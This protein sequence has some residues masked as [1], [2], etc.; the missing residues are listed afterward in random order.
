MTTTTMM[1]SI[2]QTRKHSFG[3]ISDSTRF[4]ILSHSIHSITIKK[5]HEYYMNR[6]STKEWTEARTRKGDRKRRK[7]K[8]RYRK[9]KS[10]RD[11]P[12]DRER[13][14]MVSI[15]N[16]NHEI[17]EIVG[18]YKTLCASLSLFH[19]WFNIE[20]KKKAFTA[21]CVSSLRSRSA[22]CS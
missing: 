19:F 16:S 5:K 9:T 22:C 1:L 13:W 4:F 2:C 8:K 3:N 21:N 11:I 14:K 15:G 10:E 6:W 18:P 12:R 17:L 7:K 20:D